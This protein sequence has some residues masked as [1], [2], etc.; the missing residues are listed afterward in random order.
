MNCLTICESL[1]TPPDAHFPQFVP[2]LSAHLSRTA[3]SHG[4]QQTYN[5]S[6]GCPFE[7][8]GCAFPPGAQKL[9]VAGPR[10]CVLHFLLLREPVGGR[11]RCFCMTGHRVAYRFG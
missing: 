2:Y 11:P 9:K 10:V 8:P 3:E 7:V 1:V 5:S 6:A 4:H